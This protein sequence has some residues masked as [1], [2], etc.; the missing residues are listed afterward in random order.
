MGMPIPS[1]V[2]LKGPYRPM[3]FE[4]T[5]EECIVAEGE[6]PKDLH[7]GFYRCGPT[8]KRATAQRTNGLFAMDGM[9]QAIAFENGRADFRNRWVR[10]PK[11][12]LEA[13]HGRGLFEWSDGE[14]DDWRNWGMG[15]RKQIELTKGISQGTNNINA[16]PFGEYILTSGE[17]GGPPIALD[18][19]T[20]ET[21]GVVPWSSDLSEGI[22]ESQGQHDTAFTAHPK[23]DEK[24]GVLY[25][26]TFRDREPYCTLHWVAPGGP[27]QSR[28][29]HEAP[30]N[31]MAREG[32]RERYLHDI[33]LTEDYVVMP[34]Q[35][36]IASQKNINRGTGYFTWEPDLPT[37]IAL[38]PR[39]DI[40][41]E[42]QWITGD[43]DPQYVMHTLAANTVGDK[44]YLDAP[45]FDRP[46][47]PT[48]DICNPGEAVPLFWGIA[49]STP[50]R[51]T[52]DLSAGTATSERLS[53]RP[54]ELPKV[55]QRAYGHG[56]GT[57]YM[58]GGERK[59]KGMSMKSLFAIDAETASEA[60]YTIRH[61][62]PA[63]VL[64]PTFAPRKPDSPV[65]DGYL[66][67]PVSKWAQN[68][69]EYLIF[70]TDDI[71]AGPIT[72]IEIPFALGWTPHGH[73]M[74]F[75]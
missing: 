29:I 3:R 36:V 54:A 51:W 37:M 20:L 66:I 74:Q 13:K 34:F 18:P 40:H 53:D 38:I 67:V 4:A 56:Y 47:F 32:H 62:E 65:G 42:I 48:E 22:F 60:V 46:P 11:Y 12:L 17:Q 19:L 28:D 64:E 41:G 23:W 71:P 7:G 70:D 55:D 6:I 30:Y 35:P 39:D 49:A 52:I 45:I 44:I 24:T 43:F 63:A 21:V 33:W 72:R 61:D 59:R 5:V 27:V 9:V 50:G 26:W 69:G 25:G 10:T 15:E 75:A 2:A 1:N 68:T 16:F 8:W 73:W 31:S 14:W 57:G 58:V